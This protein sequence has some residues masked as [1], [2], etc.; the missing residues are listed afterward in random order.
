MPS[1]SKSGSGKKRSASGATA[2]SEE[3][4]IVKIA[5]GFMDITTDA[6]DSSCENVTGQTI[7]SNGTS[8]PPKKKARTARRC[9]GP[10][11]PHR[12]LP[13]ATLDTRIEQARKK[14]DEHSAQVLK[15]KERLD[16]FC[17]ELSHRANE[18]VVE[19]KPVLR[20]V[21]ESEQSA[22]Q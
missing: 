13:M 12:K 4:D 3:T 18:G 10:R 22:S 21:G 19:Y 15:W 20:M 9:R 16:M 14:H 7:S 1:K 5:E 2:G 8:E 17:A 11:R 6:G